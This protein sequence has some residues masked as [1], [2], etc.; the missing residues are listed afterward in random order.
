MTLRAILVDDEKHS[1]ETTALLIRKYCPEVEI[2]AECNNPFDAIELIDEE[3]P[4]LL[5]LD[6]SM[7]R[8]NGFEM[9]EKLTYKDAAVVFTTAYDDHAL[10]GFKH[11]ATHYLIKPIEAKDLIESVQRVKKRIAD[12][13]NLAPNPTTASATPNLRN[14]IPVASLNGIEFVEV[15]KIIRC[16]SIGNYTNLILSDKKVVLVTKSLKEFDKVLLA[17]G[18][19]VR[20]HHSHLVNIQHIV[21]YIR[22]DGGIIIM[23]NMDEILVSRSRKIDVLEVLGI[24]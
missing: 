13:R 21:K 8:M 20:V 3:E 5:F 12:K 23:D 17:F 18:N 16:E 15:D 2:L 1:L 24:S 11:G 7:P 4:E 14:R 9:L 22:G 6:I 10:E 19:F